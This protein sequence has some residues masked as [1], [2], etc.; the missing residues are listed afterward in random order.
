MKEQ[1]LT[2]YR[3]S[4]PVQFG[5]P[6]DLRGAERSTSGVKRVG[7][8]VIALKSKKCCYSQQLAIQT[9]KCMRIDAKYSER[10]HESRCIRRL[11]K[12]SRG[13]RR[14]KRGISH[15]WIIAHRESATALPL[16]GRAW[17]LA[18]PVR[19]DKRRSILQ[20]WIVGWRWR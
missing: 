11:V 9:I 20:L 18:R 1:G 4:F 13:P 8:I 19:G 7:R 12:S 15:H 17:A 2:M 10:Y 14:R 3:I 16:S 6:S 5:T